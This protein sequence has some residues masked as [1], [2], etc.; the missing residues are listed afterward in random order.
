MV[1]RLYVVFPYAFGPI[2]C[3]YALKKIGLKDCGFWDLEKF[4]RERERERK[5]K[6]REMSERERIISTIMPAVCDIINDLRT[7]KS[8]GI[9]LDVQTWR[10]FK[11]KMREL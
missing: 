1:S 4:E 2:V 8:F 11:E 3:S 5:K 7:G 6:R 10:N 9:S